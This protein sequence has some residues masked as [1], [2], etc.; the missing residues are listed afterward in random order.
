MR[1]QQMIV[2]RLAPQ[3]PCI[4]LQLEMAD[5]AYLTAILEEELNRSECP[6]YRKMFLSKFLEKSDKMLAI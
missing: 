1:L 4:R 5:Y 6:E 2:E 3:R